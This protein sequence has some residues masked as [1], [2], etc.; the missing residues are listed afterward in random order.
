MPFPPH[1]PQQSSNRIKR[2]Q[3]LLS[4]PH[5]LLLL[6]KVPLPEQQESKRMIQIMEL[7]PHPLSLH[8][9]L[10]AAKSLISDLQNYF[11]HYKLCGNARHVTRFLQKT[12]Q[13]FRMEQQ[14][15]QYTI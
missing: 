6:K 3:L 2:Q 15:S 9:Q 12:R 4:P 13:K 10:V 11:L 7:H 14:N 8:P 1:P 5:P